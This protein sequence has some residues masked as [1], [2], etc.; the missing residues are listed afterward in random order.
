MTCRCGKPACVDAKGLGV[1]C[2]HCWVKA[3]WSRFI[4]QRERLTTDG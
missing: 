4:R 3:N 1:F 2:L